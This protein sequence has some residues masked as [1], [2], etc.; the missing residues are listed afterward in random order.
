MSTK[1]LTQNIF[2]ERAKEVHGDKYDYS[3]SKYINSRTKINISCVKHGKFQQTPEMHMIGQGCSKCGVEKMSQT[4]R[5]S[6]KKFI[7]MASETHN[8]KYDYSLIIYKNT[9]TKI[10]IICPTHGIFEQT[11]H[12]HLRYGC[13]YCGGTKE[14]ITKDF[15]DISTKKHGGK[16]KYNLSKYTGNKNDIIITCLK[17][18][19]F[20]QIASNHM[21]GAGCP[22]CKNSK[23]E[24]IIKNF[25]NDKNIKFIEQKKFIDCKNIN[26]LKFDFYLNELNIC[27]EYDG[28]QHFEPIKRFGGIEE[29]EQIKIRDEIKNNYCKNKNIRLLRI[30]YKDKID[31]ILENQLCITAL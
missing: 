17:H 19:D 4:K 5:L 25:L 30:S 18:G 31:V 7:E 9:D 20:K 1:K 13:D 3:L 16:Y 14:L 26:Y 28:K 11:P 10:K 6:V 24:Q 22:A 27:I 15:I 21:K 12:N 23:G 8:N 29:F 2:I